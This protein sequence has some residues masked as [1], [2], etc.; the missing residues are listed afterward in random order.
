MTK[1]QTKKKERTK[2]ARK[3]TQSKKSGSD[4]HGP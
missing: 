3:T 1:G 4:K 2:N